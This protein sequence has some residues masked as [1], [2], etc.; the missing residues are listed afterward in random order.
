[1]AEIDIKRLLKEENTYAS[2]LN[3]IMLKYY[4]EE[5]YQWDPTTLWLEFKDDFSQEVD[6]DI[7]D[8][9]SAVQLIMLNDGFF[10]RVDVFSGVANTFT[11]GAPSFTVFDPVEPAEAIWAIIEV[12]LLRDYLPLSDN[13]KSFLELLFRGV[14]IHKVVKYVITTNKPDSNTILNM[15]DEILEDPQGPLD[16]FILEQVLDLIFQAEAAPWLVDKVIPDRWK[17]AERQ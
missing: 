2:I 6:T 7:L 11:S 3:A 8:K 10:K 4:G 5:C 1:M 15:V 17:D 16:N 14:E 13:L 9:C 12:A